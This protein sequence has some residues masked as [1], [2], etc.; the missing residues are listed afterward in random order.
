MRATPQLADLLIKP[1][2]DLIVLNGQRRNARLLA[3][4][5]SERL[6]YRT[7]TLNVIHISARYTLNYQSNTVCRKLSSRLFLGTLIFANCPCNQYATDNTHSI[8][9]YACMY[10][11]QTM[12]I[13]RR[14]RRLHLVADL[15]LINDGSKAVYGAC[16]CDMIDSLCTSSPLHYP[17]RSI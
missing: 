11:L 15:C 17:A 8:Y 10:V 13:R 1:R 12:N 6:Y 5:N 9:I 16:H 4:R 2:F 14:Y 7:R 3:E